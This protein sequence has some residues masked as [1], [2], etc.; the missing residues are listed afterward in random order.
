MLI[1]HIFKQSHNLSKNAKPGWK[2]FGFP[3]MYQTDALEVLQILLKLGYR[4]DR[5]KEAVELVKSKQDEQGRWVLE[6]NVQW[7]NDHVD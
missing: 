3:L 7:P 6:N 2:K 4:D 5:M 1:H